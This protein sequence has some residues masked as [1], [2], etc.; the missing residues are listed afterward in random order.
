MI[1]SVYPQA[2]KD[3][4]VVKDTTI[5]HG[6]KAALT[7]SAPLVTNPIFRW[8][9][10]QTAADYLYEGADEYFTGNLTANTDFYVGV[11]G[12][13]YCENFPNDREKVTV[14]VRYVTPYISIS[15]PTP[16]VCTGTSVTFT[17]TALNGG[18]TPTYSWRVNGI[19]VPGSNN[20]QYT[21]IPNRN[22]VVSC[23][24]TSSAECALPISTLS[25][26]VSMTVLDY[27]AA[28]TVI[29][30]T[31][32]AYPGSSVNLMLAVLGPHIPGITYVFYEN[33]DKT[34]RLTGSTVLFDIS[35]DDY[36]VAANNGYCEG[37][38]SQI[39]LKVPCPETTE[40]ID[41][42]I[43]KVTA[44]GG[45]CWTENL[46][47][48]RYSSTGL[49]IQFS[50]TYPCAGCPAEVDTIFGLLYDWYAAVGDD[51]GDIIQGICPE[52][53]RIPSKAEW[54]VLE[55]YNATKLMSTNYWLDPPGSGTDVYGFNAF[56]AG[57]FDGVPDKYKDLYGFTGWWASD[58]NGTS[59]TASYFYLSYYCNVIRSTVLHK[60]DRLSVRCVMNN[61][62]D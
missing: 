40:D 8:Y 3:E 23:M 61:E 19:P 15:T 7:A 42:N 9:A 45:F 55:K 2:T 13:N 46:K 37:P 32:D 60:T 57:W 54:S 21:Y 17:A 43:Y 49:P 28:P 22:D 53:Y 18:T 44:L 48:T 50:Y 47:A 33:A 52:G 34:T 27:P 10:S 59:T 29:T 26:N 58:D 4:I 36:Y 11:L 41:G 24:L 6:T 39:I 16:T 25:G 5:C 56:P 1:V 31:L 51:T 38:V 14:T 30:E 35:K 20:F 62:P 12:D